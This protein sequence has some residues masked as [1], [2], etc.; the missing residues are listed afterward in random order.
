[1]P[2]EVIREV[3]VERPSSG[4]SSSGPAAQAIPAA[5][6]IQPA[7]AKQMNYIRLIAAKKNL[8][9]PAGVHTDFARASVWIDQHK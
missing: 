8:M 3:I 9:V 4:S 2:V 7:T 6:P 1:M 5:P